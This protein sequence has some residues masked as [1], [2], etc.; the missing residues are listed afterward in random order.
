MT[1]EEAEAAIIQAE[2]KV[3]AAEASLAA[4]KAELAEAPLDKKIQAKVRATRN[5]LDDAKDFLEACEAARASAQETA[6]RI[7]NEA[8]DAAEQDAL[9]RASHAAL[10]ADTA[11]DLAELEELEAKLEAVHARIMARVKVQHRGCDDAKSAAARRGRHS[12]A[13]S[14]VPATLLR[15]IVGLRIAH[16][17][18]ESGA[19]F[20]VGQEPHTWLAARWDRGSGAID[21]DEIKRARTLALPPGTYLPPA[22]CD[23]RQD[24]ADVAAW[25]EPP[26]TRPARHEVA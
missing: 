20:V 17:I 11:G 7:Q 9:K 26:Q 6:E 12:R 23:F 16:R 1:L 8:I 14:K 3:H 13:P 10:H 2:S 15:A 18:Y 24:A 19:R 22:V 25:H 4:A 21:V 5:A